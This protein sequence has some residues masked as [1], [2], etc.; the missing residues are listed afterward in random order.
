[1][2]IL[3]DEPITFVGADGQPT[4][5]PMVHATVGG[6]ATRL[7]VDTGSTDHILS[8][9]LAKRVGLRAEPGE[10]GTDSTGASVPSWSLGEVPVKI[11]HTTHQ[12]PNVIAITAP[13]P[14]EPRGI[15][16][17]LSP[18][19]LIPGAWMSLDLAGDRLTALD[20]SQADIADSLRR[21]SPELRLLGLPRAEGDTTILVRGAI[22]PHEPVITL[23]DTGGKASD[24][25]ASAVPGMTGEQTESSGRG[26]GGT[27]MFGAVVV[28]Q[29]LRVGEATIPLPRLV[30]IGD[31]EG[32]GILVGMDVLRGTILT[33]SGDPAM[34]VFWQVP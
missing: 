9:E 13:G 20:G 12:L 19:H 15:G 10:D 1:M 5:A 26:V 29:V 25:V 8:I 16:G 32:R 2:E 24:V 4:H 28:D 14:F 33:V 27:E 7:I 30:V 3:F 31:V 34:P 18:Q 11:G 21:R 6:E 22:E 17:V 23:L